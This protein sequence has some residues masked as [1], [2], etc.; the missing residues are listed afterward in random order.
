MRSYFKRDVLGLTVKKVSFSS[1]F[2]SLDSTLF[3][4]WDKV[5]GSVPIVF[6]SLMFWIKYIVFKLS[7]NLLFILLLVTIYHRSHVRSF[8]VLLPRAAQ[9]VQR[10]NVHISVP[11]LFTLD[12]L[13]WVVKRIIPLGWTAS[14]LHPQSLAELATLR[15]LKYLRRYIVKSGR[16][17]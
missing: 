15:Q 10:G 16:L 17:R 9:L 13:L 6:L 11:G 7:K 8:V 14:L 5:V 1:I 2:S 4:L 3:F 12:V